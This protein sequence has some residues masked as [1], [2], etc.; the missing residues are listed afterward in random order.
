MGDGCWICA[1][2][3]LLGG[4]VV[5]PHSI[6]ASG[7]V[8]KGVFPAFSVIGGVPARQIKFLRDRAGPA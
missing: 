2:A 3:T 5:G 4:T 1:G 8:V 6:V 7:A